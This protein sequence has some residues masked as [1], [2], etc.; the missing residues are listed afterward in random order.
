MIRAIAIMLMIADHSLLIFLPNNSGTLI[1]RATLTR[2]AEP[3]FIFV[4]A[5]LTVALGRRMKLGRWLQI[6]IVS[7]TT[8][9]ILSHELGYAMADILVSIALVSPFTLVLVRLP[10]IW[11]YISVGLAVI[12]LSFQGLTM[13]YSPALIVHQVLLTKVAHEGDWR[14]LG[15]L[16]ISALVALLTGGVLVQWGVGISPALFVILIGHPLAILIVCIVNVTGTTHCRIIIGLGRR[17]LT[18]YAVHLALLA[19]GRAASS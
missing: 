2:C 14:L 9:A 19:L 4:L 16:G 10:R 5:S 6:A 1:I 12:P 3:L 11:L 7:A 15:P 13:D 18:I 8:S 17:P